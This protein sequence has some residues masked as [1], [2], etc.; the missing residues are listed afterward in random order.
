MVS[1]VGSMNLD[2]LAGSPEIPPPKELEVLMADMETRLRA[3]LLRIVRPALDQVTD[4]GTRFDAMNKQIAKHEEVIY[5][6]EKLRMEV[7]QQ[8]EFSKLLSDQLSS[9]DA[10]QRT[11]ERQ[12]SE[13]ISQLRLGAVELNHR[14][15]E[16]QGEVRKQ[17]RN[18]QRV[19]D[20][21]SRLQ[22][23]HEDGIR[24]VGDGIFQNAKKLEKVREEMVESLKEVHRQREELLEQLFG[25]EKGLTQI[26]Q[27]IR[28]L[29]VFVAPL[30]D[31]RL[32]VE[33]LQTRQADLEVI[34]AETRE[35]ANQQKEDFKTFSAEVRKTLGALRGTFQQEA[36]K[37]V[38]HHASM[39]K[40][41]RW[42]YVEEIKMVK[43][44]HKEMTEFRERTQQFCQDTGEL[45][46]K[47]AK[48]IDALH[49]EL[50]QDIEEI[51]K[52]RKKDRVAW[53][54]EVREA[55]K[56]LEREQDMAKTIRVN[57]EFL[58][59]ILGL[60]LE[61]QRVSN[62]LTI[63][64]FS[65]RGA[66]RWLCLANEVGRRAQQPVTADGLEQQRPRKYEGKDA[67]RPTHEMVTVEFRKGLVAGEYLPGQVPFGGVV[68]ERRDLLLAHH[69]LL[70]RAHTAYVRGPFGEDL[71]AGGPT[72]HGQPGANGGVAAG[73]PAA[74][75]PRPPPK[76]E[77]KRGGGDTEEL[78]LA[79]AFKT[80]KHGEGGSASSGGA[81]ALAGSGGRQRPGSQ[82]Q[83]QAMGS[84]G[85]ASGPLGETAP[86]SELSPGG[87]SAAQPLR[88]P[89]ISDGQRGFT[90]LSGDS[91]P[92]RRSLTAR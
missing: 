83:P 7:V 2:G 44:I 72:V 79:E 73:Q 90:A 50:L 68:H 63:Q 77:S 32:N 49:R 10:Q 33:N 40:D 54:T 66:E 28:D 15:E 65:D 85:T 51:S 64:D 13:N 18:I 42:E 52:R 92:R 24:K 41:I 59:R 67:L 47:E 29:T 81:H 87:A 3:T 4:L 60:V 56:D 27:D 16:L 88:L 11:F 86:P 1:A 76:L 17:G 82:G 30:P 69:R 48:R 36:N 53:E 23:Q 55:R 14:L 22:Q 80:P 39:M 78:L 71:A 62:A 5:M 31:V 58:S 9:R 21:I 46:Q 20:E 61:G 38:A 8:A 84:R 74:S 37:L 35:C 57:V 70:Q 26:A 34:S 25:E 91:S 6:A 19:W 89:S 75:P 45:M 12:A 43:Q